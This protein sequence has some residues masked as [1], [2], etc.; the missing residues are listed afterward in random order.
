[1][2]SPSKKPEMKT[3]TQGEDE[4]KSEPSLKKVKREVM[5]RAEGREGRPS[6]SQERRKG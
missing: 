2:S 6:S 3:K 5:V 4:E 1:M